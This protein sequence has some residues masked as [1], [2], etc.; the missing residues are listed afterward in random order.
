MFDTAA[1]Q[2]AALLE[3]PPS[4]YVQEI[5]RTSH[6][7]DALMRAGAERMETIQLESSRNMLEAMEFHAERALANE[8]S[9]RVLSSMFGKFGLVQKIMQNMG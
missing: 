2:P 4:T 7:S 1:A 3:L 5:T 9:T 6:L 8:G